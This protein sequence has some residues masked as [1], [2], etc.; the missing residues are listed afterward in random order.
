M[1]DISE[2]SSTHRIAK[3]TGKI[4][5]SNDLSISQIKSNNNKKGD[6]LSTSRIA[7]IMSVKNT[8]SIIPLC[9]PI[10]I[11]KISTNFQII[12]SKNEIQCDCIVE[13]FGKTGVEMEAMVGVSCGLL[14]LYDMC[15]AVDKNM[16][17]SDVKVVEKKGGKS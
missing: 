12:E 17:I 16:I 15:K 9:H 11:T 14:T 8:S 3:A 1:V 2:K 10:N 5:F 6:V 13:C 7:S 4:T